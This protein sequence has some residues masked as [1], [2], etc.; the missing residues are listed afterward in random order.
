MTSHDE[1]HIGLDRLILFCVY[2][3]AN[4]F[5]VDDSGV[6]HEGKR[7]PCHHMYCVGVLTLTLGREETQKLSFL[8]RVHRHAT[9]VTLYGSVSNNMGHVL[10]LF[11]SKERG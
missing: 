9:G 1:T 3:C 10:Y 2:V 11:D 4:T 7:Q 8:F 5:A 6:T